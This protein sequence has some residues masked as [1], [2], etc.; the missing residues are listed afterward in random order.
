MFERM[1]FFGILFNLVIYLTRELRQGTVASSNNVTNWMG[2]AWLTPILG[3][4]VADAH[5]GRYLA[6]MIASSVYLMVFYYKNA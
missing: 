5:L 3:A 1:A 2:V 4:Y 6:F